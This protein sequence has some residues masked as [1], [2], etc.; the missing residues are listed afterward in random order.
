MRVVDREMRLVV[1]GPLDEHD[2]FVGGAT[3]SFRAF[4]LSPGSRRI[5]HRVVDTRRFGGRAHAPLNLV[6]TA[7]RARRAITTD[8]CRLRATTHAGAGRSLI[9]K[10]FFFLSE[11]PSASAMHVSNRDAARR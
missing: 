4:L 5:A 3:M 6:W 9:V 11:V 10:I 2:R 7:L 1:V 8:A